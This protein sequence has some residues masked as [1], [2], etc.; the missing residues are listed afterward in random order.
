MKQ[1]KA[2]SETQH[3]KA[4]AGLKNADPKLFP[5]FD[6]TLRSAMLKETELFFDAI[7]RE[8]PDARGPRLANNPWDT[9]RN[10]FP[11]LRDELLPR[12]DQALAR[13]ADHGS[14]RARVARR[15]TV[16]R[17]G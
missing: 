2:W 5:T 9:H 15:Q 11:L 6:D 4:W 3:A 16:C 1:F 14:G 7:I 8:D 12:A 13:L 17:G 10:H